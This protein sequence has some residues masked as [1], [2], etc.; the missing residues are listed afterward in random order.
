MCSIIHVHDRRPNGR[1]DIYIYIYIY[2]HT[3]TYMYVYITS[4]TTCALIGHI[5]IHDRRPNGRTFATDKVF[6][7][8]HK[9][10]LEDCASCMKRFFFVT[11]R[12]TDR[13]TKLSVNL[14]RKLLFIKELVQIQTWC[15]VHFNGGNR[16]CWETICDFSNMRRWQLIWADGHW[17]C[18]W[19][20]MRDFVSETICDFLSMRRWQLILFLRQYV[21]FKFC[22]EHA[23]T[24]I[25]VRHMCMWDICVCETVCDSLL[26]YIVYKWRM[27][28]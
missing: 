20:N 2:I 8:F 14:S 13:Q 4:Y 6:G 9:Y 19:D 18:F 24:Y 26:M 23:M 12:Q 22:I 27:Y 17:F 1:T 16:L 7:K 25:Y 21:T 11:D 10:R 5:N 15:T 28:M 3:H